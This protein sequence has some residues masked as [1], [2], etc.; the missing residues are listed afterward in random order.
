MTITLDL[1]DSFA[2]YVERKTPAELSYLLQTAL[3]SPDLSSSIHSNSAELA[4]IVDLLYEFRG[5]L[6]ELNKRVYEST[7]IRAPNTEVDVIPSDALSDEA[8]AQL[9][10]LSQPKDAD[11]IPDEDVDL[12]FD[13]LR[14]FLSDF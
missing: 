13:A 1:P 8:A 6:T 12:E 9:A 5:T 11:D 4:V 2:R 7:I 10:A 3:L 14:S